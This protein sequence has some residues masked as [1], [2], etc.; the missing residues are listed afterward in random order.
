MNDVLLGSVAGCVATAP[1]TLA[2]EVL[3]RRLPPADVA[4][5]HLSPSPT[6]TVCAYKGWA[7]YYSL[8]DGRPGGRDVAWTYPDPLHDALTVKDRVCFYAERTD[9]TVDGEPV[10]RPV[11]PWSSPRDQE[12]F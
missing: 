2:M 3:H 7:S 12:R 11:S 5:E 6:H 10:P 9:L 1:M 8:A 4:W